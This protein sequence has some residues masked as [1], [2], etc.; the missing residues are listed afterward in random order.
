[1]KYLAIVMLLIMVPA[2]VVADSLEFVFSDFPPFEYIEEDVATGMNIEILVEACRRLNVKP[3]FRQLPW[4]RALRNV[5]FG[6]ADAIFSLFKTR[7]RM[8]YYNYPDEHMNAVNMI[9]ITNSDNKI[10]VKD[11]KDLR[12]KRVGV[13]LGSSYGEEFDNSDWITKDWISN[14]ESLLRKQAAGRTDVSVVDE[15]VAKY[16]SKKLDLEDEFRI[17]KYVVTTNPTYVAFSKIKAKKSGADWAPKF[18]ETLKDMKKD[19]F[20]TGLQKKYSF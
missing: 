7:E 17:L 19:G 9:L 11:L 5:K 4:K 6:D 1:M 14:N 18:S 3:K 15:R 13:Y 8:K 2:I 10:S 12:G 16:W 20:V